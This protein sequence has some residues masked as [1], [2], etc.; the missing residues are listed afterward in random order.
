MKE[1]ADIRVPVTKKA[2][3]IREKVWKELEKQWWGNVET[4]GET[5]KQKGLERRKNNQKWIKMDPKW[6]KN[7]SKMNQ[8]GSKIDQI[9]PK[10][11]QIVPK[12]GQN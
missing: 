12:L 6:V 10:L 9:V 2:E 8:N 4:K 3:E 7:E 5:W 1:E 11:G